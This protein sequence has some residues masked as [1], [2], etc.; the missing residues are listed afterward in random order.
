MDFVIVFGG[1]GALAA[2]ASW[3]YNR[4]GAGRQPKLLCV[5]PAA[6]DCLAASARTPDGQPVA[7]AGKGS[8]IMAGLNCRTPSLIAWPMIKRG[9]DGFF[10][11]SDDWCRRAMQAY[12]FPTSA[13]PQITSGESGAAPLAAL[14]ALCE[15]S[16]MSVARETLSLTPQSAVLLL[17]TEGDTDP[18]NFRQII[19]A[20][21]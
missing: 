15:S 19:A 8:T 14:L 7:I 11:I 13:D 20:R 9:F 1:V 3:Y 4:Q 18:I 21:P 12:Y 6:A 16:S 10:V 5:E 17:N 2:A